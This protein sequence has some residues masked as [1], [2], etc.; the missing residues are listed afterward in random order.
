M[1][2]LE[3]GGFVLLLLSFRLWFSFLH[4]VGMA[5]SA[6]VG[7]GEGRLL[8][9]CV[10]L[11]SVSTAGTVSLAT[12][13]LLGA[14]LLSV[15]AWG[16]VALPFDLSPEEWAWELW[17]RDSSGKDSD[18][19]ERAFLVLSS[20]RLCVSHLSTSQRHGSILN[21]VK[22][23]TSL[24]NKDGP[25]RRAVLKKGTDPFQGVPGNV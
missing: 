18:C 14:E 11:P 21:L 25:S 20:T 17:Y 19:A 7:Y 10:C 9:E 4:F 15:S 8:F 16:D 3:R 12:G 5:S 23:T 1:S 6:L 24:L 22:R 2:V 13:W